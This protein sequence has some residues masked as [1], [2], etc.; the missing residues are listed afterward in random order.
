MKIFSTI[1]NINQIK[2]ILK[3]R[4]LW[5]R[6]KALAKRHSNNRVDCIKNMTTS[7]AVVFL[8]VLNELTD[9]SLLQNIYLAAKELHIIGNNQPSTN[10]DSLIITYLKARYSIDFDTNEM[11]VAG[12]IK[13]VKIIS[14]FC[15]LRYV[16]KELL[17]SVLCEYIIEYL[18]K[19]N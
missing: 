5:E 16:E 18:S 2:K 13:T 19:N 10:N 12:S 7:E 11:E 3:E 6:E 9:E 1:S 14:P 15:N 8:K 17:L 4:G